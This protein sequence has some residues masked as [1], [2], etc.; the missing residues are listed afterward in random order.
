MEFVSWRGVGK[1]G[2]SVCRGCAFAIFRWFAVEGEG[3]CS[4]VGDGGVH[5]SAAKSV[6]CGRGEGAGRDAVPNRDGKV[7]GK[8]ES[9]C[10]EDGE[11]VHVTWKVRGQPAGE[12]GLR[13]MGGT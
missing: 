7:V 10:D 9:E 8:A 2:A 13:V 5:V 11:G 6:N 3:G 4:Y 1:S 12:R